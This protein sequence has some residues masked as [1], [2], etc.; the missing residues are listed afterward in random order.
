MRETSNPPYPTEIRP[1][2]TMFGRAPVELIVVLLLILVLVAPPFAE[3]N[4]G[5]DRSQAMADFVHRYEPS[6]RI[7]KIQK[8]TWFISF[9]RDCF[10]DDEAA[11]DIY[12]TDV[13]GKRGLSTL[14]DGVSITQGSAP[15][16][17]E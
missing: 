9:R 14:C 12:F 1:E 7:T 4:F 17:R 2:R 5:A 16:L 10:P 11:Y 3:A 6:V 13:S 8:L 15:A